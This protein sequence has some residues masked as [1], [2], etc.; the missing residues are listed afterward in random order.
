MSLVSSSEQKSSYYLCLLRLRCFWMRM[1]SNFIDDQKRKIARNFVS[2]ICLHIRMRMK[3]CWKNHPWEWFQVCS[4]YTTSVSLGKVKIKRECALF[5][6]WGILAL[7]NSRRMNAIV[8]WPRIY[9]AGI[10]DV[11]EVMVA[12]LIDSI[13]HAQHISKV[14]RERHRLV[15]CRRSAF[16]Q[17]PASSW[18]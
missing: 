14:G 8:R 17:Y 3:K 12:K 5:C 1:N 10:S 9:P 15:G 18:T 16:S 4:I 7:L 11:W 2:L 13:S 6:V